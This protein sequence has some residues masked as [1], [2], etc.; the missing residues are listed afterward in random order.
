MV[1]SDFPFPSI[2]TILSILLNGNRL[3]YTCLPSNRIHEN[4]A[5]LRNGLRRD[6][7]H[8]LHH[9]ARVHPHQ[10]YHL[11]RLIRISEERNGMLISTQ[12]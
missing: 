1:S 5:G 9:Q 12:L 8:R 4:L 10:Q 11:G 2:T 7:L 3:S 6:R